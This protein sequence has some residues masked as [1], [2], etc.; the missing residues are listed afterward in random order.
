M[1]EEWGSLI[2]EGSPAFMVSLR[3]LID[4]GPGIYLGNSKLILHYPGVAL[5]ILM[6]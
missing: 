4:I 3:R 2:S 6:K 1:L 5:V